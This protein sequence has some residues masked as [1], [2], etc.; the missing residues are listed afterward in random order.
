[1]KK[2][3]LAVLALLS[4]TAAMAQVYLEPG[5]LY[6]VYHMYDFSTFEKVKVPSG[7]KL[8]SINHYGRHGARYQDSEDAYVRVLAPLAD[9]HAR[10]ALTPLGESVFNRTEEFFE[11]CRNHYGELTRKGWDQEITIAGN[12][13]RAAPHSF[14]K[15]ARITATSSF[16]KRCMMTMAAFCTGLASK[17]PGLDI[18][19][20]TSRT[21]LDATNPGDEANVNY[22]ATTPLPSPWD[23]SYSSVLKSEVSRDDAVSILL[24]LF[25]DRDAVM[26]HVKSPVNYC[27]ALYNMIAGMGCVSDDLLIDDVFTE[28][29]LV[30][31][32]KAINYGFF[33]W[34]ALKAQSCK[35]ILAT[36]LNEATADMASGQ[37]TVRLK[38]GHDVNLLAIM[39]MMQVEELGIVPERLQDLSET[40]HCWMTPMAANLELFFYGNGKS[41][42]VLPYLNGEV[43]TFSG[44]EQVHGPF[45]RWEDVGSRIRDI[46]RRS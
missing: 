42:L 22:V 4:V 7:Y 28:E 26:N 24:R 35:P 14:W 19:A 40:W 10:N 43:V 45:Y 1:M 16:S 31:F 36:I 13:Y 8:L 32:Y 29:E 17:D 6:G 41:I 34:S 12:L 38:F 15:K 18:Y 27:S 46:L 3:I 37:K 25:K 39:H 5:Q 21:L 30:R 33:E 9:A 20:C 44:L 11:L 23:A 2:A